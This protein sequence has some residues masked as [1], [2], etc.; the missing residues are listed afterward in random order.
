MKRENRDLNSFRVKGK[1]TQKINHKT[2]FSS[3]RDLYLDFIDKNFSLLLKSVKDLG[4]I[5]GFNDLPQIL[6]N[7]GVTA[8]NGLYAL[9]ISTALKPQYQEL[10]SQDQIN[11]SIKRIKDE[12][13]SL[14]S[15]KRISPVDIEQFSPI[16]SSKKDILSIFRIFNLGRVSIGLEIISQESLEKEELLF[17]EELSQIIDLELKIRT[18]IGGQEPPNHL[19]IRDSR[20]FILID[21]KIH[22][23]IKEKISYWSTRDKLL[24]STNLSNRYLSV[25][26]ELREEKT[27]NQVSKDLNLSRSTLVT[28]SQ[29]LEENDLI[30]KK[31]IKDHNSGS[32]KI[33]LSL[34]TLGE[35]ILLLLWNLEDSGLIK[36]SPSVKITTQIHKLIKKHLFNYIPPPRVYFHSLPTLN[37]LFFVLLFM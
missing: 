11:N 23:Q 6:R 27:Y 15:G 13:R 7:N 24:E 37:C 9:D 18:N 22:H 33:L 1:E 4:L 34:T 28:Y 12:T 32:K 31:E 29:A 3:I 20:D 30:E 2:H 19:T 21:P 5:H 35:K 17:L 8:L 25:L 36:Q 26:R 16:N 10:R 14:G